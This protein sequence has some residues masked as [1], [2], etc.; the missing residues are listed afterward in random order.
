MSIDRRLSAL[1][2]QA[3]RG[4]PDAGESFELPDD[5]LAHELAERLA[6][7]VARLPEAPGTNARVRA[8]LADRDALLAANR[9]ARRLAELRDA[10]R[11]TNH[12][13]ADDGRIW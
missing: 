13:P 3:A 1:E 4:N 6:D 8:L 7:E 2:Q 9:L 11:Q 5:P 10:G 12:R